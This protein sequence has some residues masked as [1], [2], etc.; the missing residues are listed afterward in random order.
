M[1]NM[2]KK[3]VISHEH[4]ELSLLIIV[5]VFYFENQISTNVTVLLAK[6]EVPA[7][8]SLTFIV[9]SVSL[10]LLGPTARPV[11]IRS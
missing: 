2:L 3:R 8:T 7:Q 6:T 4:V 9:V 5:A 11:S 1:H 10:D